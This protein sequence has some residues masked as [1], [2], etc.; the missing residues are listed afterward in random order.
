MTTPPAAGLSRLRLGSAPDSW[1]VWTPDDPRQTPWHRFLDELAEAGY[2]WLEL[3][4]YGYLPT[5][6]QQLKDEFAQ[7]G[8]Q[9]SGGAVAG[10]LHRPD[11][12]EECLAE[13]RPLAEVLRE[14]GAP[15]L[16][17]LPELYRDI[18]EAGTWLQPGELDHEQWARL[19]SDMD[20]LGRI[21][22]EEYG[23]SLVFHPHADSHVDTQDR[24]VRF[25]ETTDPAVTNLCL[26]TGHISY[27]GGDNLELIRGFGERVRYVHLKQVDPV[28]LSQVE[29]EQLSFAQAVRLGAMV[30]PPTGVPA[31]EPLLAELAGLDADLFAIVEQDMY[32]CDPDTPLPIATRTREYFARCGLGPGPRTS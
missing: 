26:D 3:G 18:D 10:G 5:D 20:R 17:F 31:M 14:L 13:A 4:P 29:A 1:G 24:V 30:E 16:V 8:L 21:V 11:G 6:P 12:L 28:V 32:P 19:T 23:L 15:Y 25:L 7:R 27:C 2:S 22:A 9:L